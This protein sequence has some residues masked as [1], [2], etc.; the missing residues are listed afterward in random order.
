MTLVYLDNCCFNRPFDDQLQPVV[1]FEAQ[2]KLLIQS[3]IAEGNIGLVWSF[4]SF[5]ENLD[6]PFEERR[7]QIAAWESLASKIITRTPDVQAYAKSLM[8]L[9]IKSKDAVHIACAA[10][11]KADY[12]ITTD[13]KILNKTVLDVTLINPIDFVRRHYNEN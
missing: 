6:N 2:A 13:K 4:M 10:T 5:Q 3:E 11:A 7:N 9:G 12:F 1:H 8:P